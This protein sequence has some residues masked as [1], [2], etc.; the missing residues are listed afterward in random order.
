MPGLKVERASVGN[1]LQQDASDVSARLS[2][3]RGPT[4]ERG[5][6]AAFAI[7]LLSGSGVFFLFSYNS[8]YG[9]DALEYLV[10]GR[11]LGQGMSLYDFMPS[12][13]FGIYYLVKWLTTAGMPLGH[14]TLSL[15]IMV[16]FA[17]CVSSVW[18]VVNRLSSARAALV[19]AVTIEENRFGFEPEITAKMAR[20][21]VRVYEVPISYY[22]RS[23]AEGKKL[24]GAMESER[25]GAF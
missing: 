22:G 15:V 6:K 2:S 16:I 1:G 5:S 24:V 17:L 13:S 3:E 20:Q 4:L 25:S 10:I 9:Y 21:N 12:K 14:L 23:Y 18:F 11:L 8:G 19:A 7:F